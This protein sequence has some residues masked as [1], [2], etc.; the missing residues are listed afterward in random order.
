MN[1]FYKILFNGNYIGLLLLNKENKFISSIL[2]N[3]RGLTEIVFLNLV[4]GLNYI[5]SM[6]HKEIM[7]KVILIIKY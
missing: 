4:F 7:S 6:F 5:E 2:L 3:T 1:R